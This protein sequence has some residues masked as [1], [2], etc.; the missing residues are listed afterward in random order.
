MKKELICCL[1]MLCFFSSCAHVKPVKEKAPP[2]TVKPPEIPSPIS[3]QLEKEREK[4]S[5][6]EE[7]TLSFSLREADI[8]DIVRAVGKQAGYNVVVEPDVKGQTTVDLKD[9]TVGKALRYILEPLNYTFKIEDKTIYVSRPKLETRIFHV[10]YLALKKTG[11]SNVYATPGTVGGSTTSSGS[12]VTTSST[13]GSQVSVKSD[14]DSDFWKTLEENI[15]SLVSKEGRFVVNKQA[16][17]VF[18]TDSQ[19]KLKGIEMFLK[20]MEGAVH[21]QVM[22]EAKIVEVQLNDDSRQGVN[23]K[24]VNA[25]INGVSI[26]AQQAFLNP[27]SDPTGTTATAGTPFARLFMGTKYLDSENT[28]ID[29]LRTYGKVETISNP[30][31]ATM[32]NQ[33]AIIKVTT[34][35]VYFDVQQTQ[36]YG[37]SNPTITYT[38]KFVDVGLTLD[39][40]PQIDDRGNIIM[41]IHPIMSEKVDEVTTPSNNS[42]VPVLD[43][44]EVDTIIKVSEGETVVIGGLIKTRKSNK[45][46]GTKGLMNVPILGHLFKL[47]ETEDQ[48]SELV[49]FMTPRIIQGN[50]SR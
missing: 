28:F 40:M 38:P 37:T 17:L 25:Q 16:M 20:A 19:E 6:K 31:I 26:S 2:P 42:K 35:D 48:R 27:L 14:T 12:T 30:K 45:D 33:R 3:Y 18:V 23:W 41:N 47:N 34:Q 21:R 4:P 22:I 32:N 39:V 10:N 8:R 44:R 15:K 9:V 24:L 50:G 36:N 43:V 5:V 1:V 49:V 13:S 7:D 11:T 29:L 46:T